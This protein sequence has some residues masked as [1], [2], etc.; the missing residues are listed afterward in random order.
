MDLDINDNSPTKPKPRK[1]PVFEKRGPYTA[2]DQAKSDLANKFIGEGSERSS[3]NAYRK[4]W[5][6]LANCGSYTKEDTI[7]I[8]AEGNR[9]GRISPNL[10][11]ITLATKAGATIITDI[12]ADRNRAY[13]IGEQSVAR[14]LK[15]QGYQE[16]SPGIWKPI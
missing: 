7:F 16:V 5:G 11:E 13:N 8:S 14:F 3:T 10:H 6:P 2:K 12:P 9:S 1:N 15:I 4:A